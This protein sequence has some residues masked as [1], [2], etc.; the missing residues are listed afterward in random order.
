MDEQDLK[1]T[2]KSVLIVATVSSFLTP[3]SLA[4]VNVALPRIGRAFSADAITLNWVATIYLLT[5]AMFLVPFGKISDIYGRRKIFIYGMW[6]FTVSS[7]CLGLAPSVGS[8]LAFRALQGIGSSMVFGTGVAM[9][10][11]VYPPGER[12]HALGINIA[13]V[14]L[15]LS[16][17]PFVGGLLTQHLG[18]RSVFLFNVP[19]GF[20]VIFLSIKKLKQEWA[21]ARG[22]SLD[23][24]GSL[25]YALTLLLL[26][27]GFSRLPSVTGLLFVLS[28]MAAI[29]AFIWW[30]LRTK[31]PILEISLF[32][33]NKVFTLSNV[34]AL[35]NYS[36]TF[37]VGFLLS[38]YLQYIKGLTPQSA[39]L[40]LVSQ[41][42][43]QAAFSPLAGKLS[44]RIEPRLVAS[45]GM[46]LTTVGLILLA[47]LTAATPLPYIIA[48]LAV[49]GFGFALFSSPNSNAIMSSVENRFYGIASSTL[50]TTRLIGQML[51]MGIAMVVFALFIGKVA[52][53]PP[54]Y[55]LLVKSTKI[56]FTIF[57]I[58]CVGGTFASL[59]RGNLR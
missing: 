36:A 6:V 34:A 15:G 42:I 3:L 31:T 55:G 53:T 9:L 24:A 32:V 49:L 54:Y 10:T 45:A 28:G 16:C 14:Y 57:A 12:G 25:I 52:I 5:A 22:E 13:A 59:T 48:S 33:T 38:L 46:A 21:E 20:F 17:G 44:D 18:W 35:I 51:S 27:Y 30:E 7:L 4:T 39:G 19:L 2:Q 29:G 11:S 50:A 37:A 43:V 40:V 26:M 56:I 8:L 41:P 1:T 47:L 58:L 23:I